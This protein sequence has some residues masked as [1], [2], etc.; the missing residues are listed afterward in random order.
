MFFR[1]IYILLF[2][3]FGFSFGFSQGFKAGLILG[4]NA[5]QIEGDLLFGYNKLGISAG[6]RVGYGIKEN[7]DLSLEFIYSQRGAKE[8]LFNK[9]QFNPDISL[10]Y[11]ELPIV[12]SLKDWLIENENYHKVR[13]DLGFSFG[14]LFSKGANFDQFQPVLPDLEKIDFSYLAAVG[15]N[16]NR[17]IG[18]SIRY[19]RSLTPIYGAT[20]WD[21][22]RMLS[23]FLTFRTEYNF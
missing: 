8:R 23:Y 9:S 2:F 10:N 12:F 16:F 18:F 3:V 11:L 20:D 22:N 4:M 21:T 6:A 7:M 13:I 15:F 5:A 14:Y 17:N 19:T 1:L